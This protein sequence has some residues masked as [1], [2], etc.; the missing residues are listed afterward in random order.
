MFSA[1]KLLGGVMENGLS[2]GGLLGTAAKV[3]GVA[4]VGGVA[5]GAYRHYKAGGFG[6]SAT[7]PNAPAPF[8]SPGPGA[9]TGVGGNPFAG[10]HNASQSGN[11]FGGGTPQI[12]TQ[13][14]NPFGDGQSSTGSN[15]WAQTTNPQANAASQAAPPSPDEESLALLLVRA[16][17][18]AAYVDGGLDPAERGRIVAG[19]ENA[20]MGPNERQ[21]L[22]RELGAPRVPCRL[23][24]DVTDP[25]VAKQIYLVTLLAID[26]DTPAERA[27]VAGL[28][29]FLG[30]S[31]ADVA[32]IEQQ[33]GG[34][35]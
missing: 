12:Q 11:P 27:Y 29:F 17:I 22:E 15:P 16:M 23:F 35:V 14:G 6:G 13:T 20:G 9:P 32:A 8:G 21:A 33:L 7:G 25:S 18:A 5:Y 26:R 2:G 24:G 31:P 1:T 3:A 30:L 34:Q 28:P 10:A 19:A 4:A